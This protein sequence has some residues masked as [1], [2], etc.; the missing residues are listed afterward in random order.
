M[1]AD[2]KFKKAIK[3]VYDRLQAAFEKSDGPEFILERNAFEGISDGP[4]GTW[5]GD[6]EGLLGPA[7]RTRRRVKGQ[8]VYDETIMLAGALD[9]F[10]SFFAFALSLKAESA[11]H[12]DQDPDQ[13]AV[14]A[15]AA[16]TA[17]ET[18]A[19]AGTS[20]ATANANAASAEAE[21]EAQAPAQAPQAPA[22]VTV[23]TPPVTVT[24][25]PT[26]VPVMPVPVQPLSPVHELALV[27]WIAPNKSGSSMTISMVLPVLPPGP[28]PLLAAAP[29]APADSEAQEEDEETPLTA[30][31][32][33]S[34]AVAVL[35]G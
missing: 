32:R 18:H 9:I 13:V 33:P 10:D 3:R 11:G 16:Q 28:G 35:N 19:D 23:V 14:A 4:S 5:I 15:A 34:L 30:L 31:A 6:I 26:P 17:I 20:T 2:K 24:P 21:A 7:L 1:I 12:Q 22:P 27:P 25:T 8:D 29:A